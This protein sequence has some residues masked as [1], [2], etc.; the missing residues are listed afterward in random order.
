MNIKIEF[1]YIWAIFDPQNYRMLWNDVF[2]CTRWE[3]FQNRLKNNYVEVDNDDGI[4]EQ[5]LR[6]WIYVVRNVNML[7]LLRR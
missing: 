2:F 5:K 1:Y 3:I 6:D 4:T 7:K